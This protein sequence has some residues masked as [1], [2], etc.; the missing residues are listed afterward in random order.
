MSPLG[1]SR[2]SDQYLQLTTV[3]ER[4]NLAIGKVRPSMHFV[5]GI[6]DSLQGIGG[7]VYPHIVYFPGATTPP[8]YQYFPKTHLT[9]I[10]HLLS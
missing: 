9:T 8:A 5:M 10:L 3:T 2:G 7:S 6:V 4:I 1:T